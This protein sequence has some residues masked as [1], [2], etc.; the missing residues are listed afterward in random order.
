MEELQ[1][2]QFK[3]T[4]P[5]FMPLTHHLAL[6]AILAGTAPGRI[7]VD[8]VRKP[9]TAVAWFQHRVFLA[10]NRS[11]VVINQALNQL[12][13]DTYYP[14]MHVLGLAQSAFTLVYTPG[15]ERV[16]TEVLAGKYPMRGRRLYY[17]LDPTRHNRQPRL[18][19]GLQLRAVDAALLADTRLVNPDY[20]TDEMVSER[21]SVTDFL[22]KSFGFCLVQGAEIVG[23]CMSEYNT[24]T[25]C[26]LGIEIAEPWRRRGL[27][28]A[29]ASATI[30]E[31]V[32]R[33]YT[34]IGWICEADNHAS[35]SL[36]QKLGFAL[37]H[38]DDTYFAF[39]DPV[40]NLGINGNIQ[41][42]HQNYQEAVGWYQKAIAQGEAPIWLWWNQAAAWAN[43]GNQSRTF[44][45][46]NH[47]LDAGF[48]DRAQL[49]NSEHFR[50]YRR[51]KEWS[52]LLARL[53][54]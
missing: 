29:V 53:P 32:S 1:Q 14:E 7:F 38:A 37:V 27:A 25:A 51:T 2:T 35:M 6:E 34:E 15:W 17:R 31:A 23:W 21:P 18:P 12:F 8:D 24:A 39:I 40:L 3:L 47:L 11:D 52:V 45:C 22:E 42:Q 10:G 33:G 13:T 20:V 16:M 43:L 41:L 49:E 30:C 4:R 5:L 26:E 48:D 28:A 36:A 50:P 46:L 19:K 9:R 54:R 44:Y